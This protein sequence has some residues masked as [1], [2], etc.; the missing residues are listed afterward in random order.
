MRKKA[1]SRVHKGKGKDAGVRS[2]FRIAGYLWIARNQT[3]CAG[4][5][6][7]QPFRLWNAWRYAYP[8]MRPATQTL[9][10]E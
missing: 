8:E 10:I 1:H 4:S 5:D 9:M 3:G 6:E 7:E 2:P